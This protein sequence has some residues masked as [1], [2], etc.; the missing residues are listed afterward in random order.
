MN[1]RYNFFRRMFIKEAP[2]IKEPLAKY[3]L[4]KSAKSDHRNTE[5]GIV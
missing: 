1:S 5:K 2:L 4:T 3:T